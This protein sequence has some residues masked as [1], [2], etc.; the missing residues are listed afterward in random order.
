M[1][2]RD[3]LTAAVCT[4]EMQFFRAFPFA[5][6]GLDSMVDISELRGM[7]IPAYPGVCCSSCSLHMYIIAWAHYHHV[8]YM[9]FQKYPEAII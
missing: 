5:A 8:Q 1:L 6:K 7:G 3:Y 9:Y 2:Y 4:S